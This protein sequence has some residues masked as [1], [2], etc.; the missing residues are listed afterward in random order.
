M[1]LLLIALLIVS[2]ND[3]ASSYKPLL[4]KYL[5]SK[6]E[7]LQAQSSKFKKVFGSLIVAATLVNLPTIDQVS[8]VD[9]YNN[10][11][12][13]PTA[14]GTRVNSDAESLL[15]YGMSSILTFVAPQLHMLTI[16]S[17]LHQMLDSCLLFVAVL[18]E[19]LFH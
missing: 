18:I 11:L 6:I 4:P 14:I 7:I 9:R 19:S 13:A 8:A 12:N 3:C 17:T 5:S 2:N 16:A 1:S 10:K 15:R